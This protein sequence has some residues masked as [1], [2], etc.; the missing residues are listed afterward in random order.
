MKN[1]LLILL[2]VFGISILIDNASSAIIT[3]NTSTSSEIAQTEETITLSKMS[4]TSVSTS[5]KKSTPIQTTPPVPAIN[6]RVT[7]HTDN[8]KSR[9]LSYKDIYKT[10][11]L[12]YGHNS[13]N[14]LGS[15]KSLGVGSTFSVT[16]GNATTTYQIH[17][18]KIFLKS[19]DYSLELCNS[20]YE[21]CNGGT[22]YLN[23]LQNAIFR[24]KK[25]DIALFTCDGTGLGGG[26]ATHRRVVF[27]NKV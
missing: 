15:L 17:D 12:V 7:I 1:Y 14:L 23:S 2:S 6:Y 13:T 4:T 3:P 25:Y 5:V 22:Y 27:A 19:D 10:K 26:D 9:N 24:D 8:V 18:I 21:N 16:E 11:K 20:G